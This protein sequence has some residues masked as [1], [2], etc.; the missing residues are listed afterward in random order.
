[1]S[2]AGAEIVVVV[3]DTEVLVEHDNEAVRLCSRETAVRYGGPKVFVGQ[4][5][6]QLWYAAPA[7]PGLELPTELGF[8]GARALFAELPEVT[9]HMVGRAIQN[10]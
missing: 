1:M 2:E 8:R 6:D 7:L 3:R 10:I 4:S 5:G 9:V